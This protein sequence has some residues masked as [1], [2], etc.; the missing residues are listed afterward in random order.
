MSAATGDRYPARAIFQILIAVAAG[1]RFAIVLLW[2]LHASSKMRYPSTLAKSVLALGLVRSI[3]CGIFVYITSTDDHDVHDIGMLL[4]ILATFPYMFC[5]IWHERR[6]T[7]AAIQ[8]AV[9]WRKRLGIIFVLTLGPLVYCY[10]QHKVHQV[11]G[12]Y[13]FYAL[14]EWSLIFYDVAFDGCSMW[15]FQ[16]LRVRS[17]TMVDPASV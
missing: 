6:L 3:T 4:Y 5:T 10:L 8:Q 11:K 1:P 9:R 13:S 14:F 2:Y 12:A 17:W 16:R 15:C 7:G